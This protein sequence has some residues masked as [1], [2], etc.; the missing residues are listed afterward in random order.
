VSLQPYDG[1]GLVPLIDRETKIT[2]VTPQG[3][4]AMVLH[5]PEPFVNGSA[6]PPGKSIMVPVKVL[7]GPA[8]GRVLEVDARAIRL[9][10][11]DGGDR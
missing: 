10:S 2:L 1:V 11:E 5:W 3:T 8:A 4:R 7:D 6:K 9:G